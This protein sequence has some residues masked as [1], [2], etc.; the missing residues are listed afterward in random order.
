M[1]KIGSFYVSGQ[2]GCKSIEVWKKNVNQLRSGSC[3]ALL[4]TARLQSS[5]NYF[6]RPGMAATKEMSTGEDELHGVLIVGGGIC[7]LAT[8]LALHMYE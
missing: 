2:T 1:N 3:A 7:G 6:F 4:S 8:A 5:I